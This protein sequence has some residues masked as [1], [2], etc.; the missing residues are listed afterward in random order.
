MLKFKARKQRSIEQAAIQQAEIRNDPATFFAKLAGG[1]MENA[2]M[3]QQQFEIIIKDAI[4][5][6]KKEWIK[7]LHEENQL[8]LQVLEVRFFL[9]LYVFCLSLSLSLSLDLSLSSRPPPLSVYLL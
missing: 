3:L 2:M 8:M 4:L 7:K 9:C 5:N 1:Q 6:E